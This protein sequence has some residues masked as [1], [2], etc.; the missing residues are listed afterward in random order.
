MLLEHKMQLKIKQRKG[1]K[2]YKQTNEYNNQTN[3]KK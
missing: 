2:I 3:N 1:A